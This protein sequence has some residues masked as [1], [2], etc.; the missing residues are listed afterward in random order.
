MIPR[1][2]FCFF[3]I[4]AVMAGLLCGVGCGGFP[5][6]LYCT[7]DD[8]MDLGLFMLMCSKN[9]LLMDFVFLASRYCVIPVTRFIGTIIMFVTRNKPIGKSSSETLQETQAA[10]KPEEATLYMAR[11]PSRQHRSSLGSRQLI[12]SRSVLNSSSTHPSSKP[13]RSRPTRRIAIPT[14]NDFHESDH[15]I[16]TATRTPL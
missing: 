2:R 10:S 15:H 11:A 12:L 1:A 16:S 8:G 13:A 4:G 5:T 7:P 3:W 14:T 6:S 9:C